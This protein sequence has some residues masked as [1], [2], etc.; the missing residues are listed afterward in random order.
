MAAGR[1]S[2][3]QR[4]AQRAIGARSTTKLPWIVVPAAILAVFVVAFALKAFL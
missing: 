3:R 2:S 1:E 4:S